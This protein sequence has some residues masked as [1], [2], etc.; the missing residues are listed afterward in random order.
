MIPESVRWLLAKKKKSLA[1]RIVHKVARINKVILSAPI[2]DSFK[3]RLPLDVRKFDL[4]IFLT[5]RGSVIQRHK[6]A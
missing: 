4:C 6:V 3:E 5:C 1:E 2:K